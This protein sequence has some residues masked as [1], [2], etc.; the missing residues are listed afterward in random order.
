M[1]QNAALCGNG[2]KGNYHMTIFVGCV[3][4]HAMSGAW[5]LLAAGLF[6]R[7]DSLLDALY[8]KQVKPGLFYVGQ[9]DF[10]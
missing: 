3:G 6:T 1:R 10:Y 4:T 9:A 2:L 7:D 5:G 8:L